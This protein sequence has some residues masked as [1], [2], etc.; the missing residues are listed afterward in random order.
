MIY[1]L[2]SSNLNS[3]FFK[4]VRPGRRWPYLRGGAP[5]HNEQPRGALDRGRGQVHD[6]RGRPRRR[7]QNKFSGQFFKMSS[8]NILFFLTQKLLFVNEEPILYDFRI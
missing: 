1:E 2:L 4:G 3:Y 8:I 7:W 6:C 5:A